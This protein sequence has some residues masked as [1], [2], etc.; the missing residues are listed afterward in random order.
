MES[1]ENARSPKKRGAG[2]PHSERSHPSMMDGSGGIGHDAGRKAQKRKHETDSGGNGNRNP[3]RNTQRMY[4]NA[5]GVSESR[6]AIRRNP[7]RNARKL[8]TWHRERTETTPI[9][10]QR[11]TE[12]GPRKHENLQKH[13]TTEKSIPSNAFG[14]AGGNTTD[15]ISCA[16]T[17]LSATN[18]CAPAIAFALDSYKMNRHRKNGTQRRKTDEQD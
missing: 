17:A 8:R 18:S 13:K 7:K 15:A 16:P 6:S 4:A 14:N 2:K 9:E 12:D 10:V 1:A 5:A 3:D 11:K